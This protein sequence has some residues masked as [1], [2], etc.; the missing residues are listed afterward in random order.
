MSSFAENLLNR[1]HD[2]YLKGR[3]CDVI[4]RAA[5]CFGEL[6]E[7]E[8]DSSSADLKWTDLHCHKIV[9]RAA[10]S[11]F[12]RIFCHSLT[13]EKLDLNGD[14]KG[15][16]TRIQTGESTMLQITLNEISSQSLQTLVNFAYTGIVQI[17]TNMM[18]KIIQDLKLLNV[19]PIIDILEMR[20][21][22]KTSFANCV[23]NLILSSGL[24]NFDLYRKIL[25]FILEEFFRGLRGNGED[26]KI[27]DH[28]L[29]LTKPEMLESIENVLQQELQT[30]SIPE[31]K[32][33]FDILLKLLKFEF[34][35]EEEESNL[36]TFLASKKRGKCR[37]HLEPILMHCYSDGEDICLKCLTNGHVRHHIESLGTAKHKQLT[38]VWE[39]VDV[40]LDYLKSSA[41]SRISKLKELAK[42]FGDEQSRDFAILR[43]CAEI[44][45]RMDT[46]A[47]MFASGEL[48]AA[49][50]DVLAFERFVGSLQKECKRTRNDF[51]R[52]KRVSEE[53]LRVMEKRCASCASI[54]D[55]AFEIQ[56]HEDMDDI[57]LEQ[58]LEIKNCISILKRARVLGN[59]DLYEGAFDF[60]LQNF[61]EVVNDSG[62]SFYQRI[63]HSVLECFLKSDKLKIESEDQVLL[64]VEKWLQFDYGL[65]KKLA[66][67][68]LS[69]VRFGDI[70]REVLQQIKANPL[71]VLLKNEDCK[72]LLNDAIAGAVESNPRES[73][74]KIL[75]FGDDGQNLMLDSVNFTWEELQGP[76]HGLLYSIVKIKNNV[77]LIGGRYNGNQ[78]LDMVSIYN[79]ETKVWTNGPCMRKARFLFGTCVSS[80]NI[81][82]VMGG[83]EQHSSVE[84]LQCDCNGD[85]IGGWQSLPPMNTDRTH[86]EAACVDDK[87]YAIGGYSDIA[88]VEVFDPKVN[89]WRYCN[90]MA[91]GKDHHTVSTHKGEI[92][93]FGCNG[94]CEKYNPTTDNWTPISQ[95]QMISKVDLRSSSVLNGKIYVIGGNGCSEV[96]V[97]D[98]KT[99]SWSKGP[100]MPKVIGHTKCVAIW[101]IHQ[102]VHEK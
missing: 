89:S 72:K 98:T 30:L 61:L 31:D 15:V 80:T 81:I 46:L 69:H 91:Q 97:Y 74:N 38:L 6:R 10:S 21:Q 84:M 94:F 100:Q 34:V 62:D 51:E 86:F 83:Y 24:E 28:H 76:N 67:K 20:I 41:R 49:D 66:V 11:F 4:L 101:S 8:P 45:P 64:V 55:A 22:E 54:A 99:N 90:S 12:D 40:E 95:L 82:Y 36:T 70:S 37:V 96:D 77:Y 19:R 9:L 102:T 52:A 39:R 18:K 7:I 44:K 63:S 92:Y 71:H 93:V 1:L 16:I 47:K 2:L 27:F 26:D 75:C 17:D 59:Q 50:N 73:R 88:T 79:V 57:D 13:S 85:P 60:I 33:L 5:D 42:I 25:L 23:P 43:S 65:R 35:S 32:V 78:N 53:L 48:D 87:I 3:D 56:T 14:V 58:P 29:L 68:L